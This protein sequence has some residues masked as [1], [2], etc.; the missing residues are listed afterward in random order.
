LP[1]VRRILITGMSGTGKSAVI[2][3]LTEL[4]YKAI[5]TDWNPDWETPPSPGDHNADGPGWL[6]RE[7]RIS[8]LLAAED[9]EVLFMSACVPNQSRFFDRF[10]HIVL[11]TA[12]PELTVQRLSTRTDNPY[13]KSAEEVAE[14]LR[15]KSTI[16]PMLRVGATDEIDTA[17]PLREVVAQIL[18]IARK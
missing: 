9:G 1:E 18:D 8:D 14:V 17:I 10:D 5:D 13:G 2:K 3:R 11:L 4:G 15:F 7:D 12:S 16:E 6:W